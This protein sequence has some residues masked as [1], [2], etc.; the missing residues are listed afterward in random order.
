MDAQQIARD[1][2]RRADAAGLADDPEVIRGDD[3][4]QTRKAVVEVI[5]NLVHRP[6]LSQ[7]VAGP[8]ALQ[9]VGDGIGMA[10]HDGNFHRTVRI[11]LV[12]LRRCGMRVGVRRG[13]GR[14]DGDVKHLLHALTAIALELLEELE[15]RHLRGRR[16]AGGMA[17][18]L[19]ELL[20]RE[21]DALRVAHAVQR[22]FQIQNINMMLF[23]HLRRQIARRVRQHGEASHQDHPFRHIP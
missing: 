14:V 22:D 23:C 4:L 17:Q 2:R 8:A 3:Q 9:A 20:G 6:A 11:F 19:R 1:G 15:L 13:A 12:K 5:D 10:V 7:H 18:H 16:H 21:I